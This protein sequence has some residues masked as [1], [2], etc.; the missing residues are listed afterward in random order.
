[1]KYQVSAIIILCGISSMSFAITVP[2]DGLYT[3]TTQANI[4]CKDIHS[5]CENNQIRLSDCVAQIQACREANAK[6]QSDALDKVSKQIG[7][8]NKTIDTT[9]NTQSTDNKP[10]WH[11]GPP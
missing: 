2:S 1:M 10:A 8:Q 7:S 6:K 9:T 4:L 5:K 3:N 11:F